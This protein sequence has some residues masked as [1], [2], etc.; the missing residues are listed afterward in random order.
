MESAIPRYLQTQQTRQTRR[1]QGHVPPYPSFVARFTPSV[2]RV[3]MAYFGAQ[4]RGE[5]PNEATSSL[6]QMSEA[7]ATEHGPGHWDRATYIDEAGYT[8]VITIAYWDDAEVFDTWFKTQGGGW[9][10]DDHAHDGV[11][12]FAEVLR[13]RVEHFETLFSADNRREGIAVVAEAM[14]DMV[15][16]HAYWG[17][18][19]DRIPRSQTD[20][21]APAG[22]P[23][24]LTQDA[25]RRVL[26]HQNLCLIRSGQDWSDTGAEE[27][28]MYLQ[29]VE[30]VLRKGM[31]FLR[32]D[33]LSVGC[34]ANRY[35]TVIDG[36]GEITDKTFGMSLW[37]S[38]AA[39]ESWA[40][41]HP[42]HV[43][44]FAAAMRHLSAL[45]PAAQL[46]LYHEVT[47]ATADEQLFEYLNCHDS[48]GMLRAR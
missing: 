45:G 35:M 5:A 32:D 44:I 15:L 31:D 19:R 21:M 30:P 43:A 1:R 37:K 26:P 36:A 42:T 47:V 11:G 23:R 20:D 40:E 12:Y 14:S 38:L 33:G 29:D 39:L 13:P 7:L 8:N 4:Y 3:V 28:R 16:E 41:S 22:A 25:R 34:F 6:S 48:T 27:R 46:K 18:A 2:E 17:G 9:T 24:I 10:G